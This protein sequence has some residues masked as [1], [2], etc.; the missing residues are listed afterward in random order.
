MTNAS[1]NTFTVPA[2]ASVAYPTGTRINILNLGAGACTPTAG[3]GVTISGTIT[4]LATNGSASVIKTATNT[5]SYIP[6]GAGAGLTFIASAS[7]SGAS[8]VSF[9]SQFSATYDNYRIIG[10]LTG[11]STTALN[12]RMRTAVPADDTTAN[13]SWQRI[14]ASTSTV[15]AARSTGSTASE[16]AVIATAT[17]Y[18]VIDI[19]APNL[20]QP[21]ALLAQSFDTVTAPNLYQY[22]SAHNVSTAFP[23]IT[24]FPSAGTVAGYVALYGYALT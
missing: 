1:A 9:T 20:A 16:I 14:N 24:L 21:T 22:T 4:A 17:G 18:F 7:P 12:Y 11:G 8:T 3:A 6:S 19:I 10:R 15:G 5:W 2:N 23:G 13:Y